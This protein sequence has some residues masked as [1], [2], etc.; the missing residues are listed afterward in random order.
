MPKKV[1]YIDLDNTLADFDG[2]LAELSPEVRASYEGHYDHIPGVYSLLKPMPGAVEAF[3]EL[4][5][6]FDVYILS[7]APWA[8]P[9]AWTDKLQWVQLVFGVEEESPAYKRLIITHHKD[10]NVGDFLVDDQPAHGASEF[11]GEWLHFGEG[12]PFPD[13][14]TVVAYLRERAT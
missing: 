2:R 8:N 11:G 5:E 9:T 1:L 6:L 7:T 14:P 3:R 4:S 10:L 13:W 12:R